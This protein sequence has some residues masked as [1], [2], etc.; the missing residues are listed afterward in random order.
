[1]KQSKSQPG[2]TLI[3]IIVVVAIVVIISGTIGASLSTLSPQRLESE[4]T[5][6]LGDLSW[7]KSMSLSTHYH[8]RIDFDALNDGVLDAADNNTYIIYRVD[9]NGI[10][11]DV[12]VRRADLDIDANGI[13][14]SHGVTSVPALEFEF[15]YPRGDVNTAINDPL[16]I[17]LWR[18]RFGARITIRNLTGYISWEPL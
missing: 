18:G 9:P 15:L 5:Q 10:E 3:E 17:E 8:Y 2:H 13:I 7:A 16:E 12:V 1:M 14:V 4:V 11:P 6:L